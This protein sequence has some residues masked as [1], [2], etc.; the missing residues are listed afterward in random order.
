MTTITATTR[1]TLDNRPTS[2]VDI[3]HHGGIGSSR[4]LVLEVGIV[5]KRGRLADTFLIRSFLIV[6]LETK[7]SAH[8]S[9]WASEEFV[10]ASQASLVPESLERSR[11]QDGLR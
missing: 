11:V 6:D 1:D 7:L 5:A 9:S 10:N 2:S 4:S 3:A 8:G